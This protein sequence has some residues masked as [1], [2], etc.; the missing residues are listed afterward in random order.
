MDNN[1]YDILTLD[2]ADIL[3]IKPTRKKNPT[4]KSRR[5]PISP[6]IIQSQFNQF[7]QKQISSQP[8]TPPTT[9]DNTHTPE[10]PS[11]YNVDNVVPYGC[12][13]NGV[14]PT[15]KT[16]TKRNPVV[17]KST[18]NFPILEKEYEFV[19]NTPTDSTP[20]S[21]PSPSITLH[22]GKNT[23]VRKR[24]KKLVSSKKR[25][26]TKQTYPVGRTQNKINLY[27]NPPSTTSPA[28]I[29]MTDIRKYLM[30]HN[31]ISHG[32]VAPDDVLRNIYNNCMTVGKITNTNYS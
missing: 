9:N 6:E 2:N 16:I 30:D 27:L 23:T 14:K 25:T 19:M 12:L 11:P 22:G 28:S 21:T 10:T 13:K 8:T 1:D 20:S 18:V 17:L 31:L 29:N 3:T 26:T 7:A 15:F 32:C 5:K 4:A 24:I